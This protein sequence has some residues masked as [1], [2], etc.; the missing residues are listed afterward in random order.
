MYLKIMSQDMI[1][2]SIILR[3]SDNS[4]VTNLGVTPYWLVRPMAYCRGILSVV[5]NDA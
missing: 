5:W 2:T 1:P 4:D 3:P